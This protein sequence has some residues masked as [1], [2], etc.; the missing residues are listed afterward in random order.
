MKLIIGLGNPGQQYEG[1]RHNLG[2][3]VIDE[4]RRHIADSK[5]QIEKK[6]KAEIIETNY[7]QTAISHTLN[8]FHP[9]N[10][11]QL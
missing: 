8:I 11:N 3:V 5:W 9:F 2:F 4:L 10:S 1:T 7:K 6:F